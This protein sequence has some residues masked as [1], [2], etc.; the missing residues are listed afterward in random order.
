MAEESG[1]STE[2]ELGEKNAGRGTWGDYMLDVNNVNLRERGE[3]SGGTE[4]LVRTRAVIE[5]AL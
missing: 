3:R 1:E 2:R 5:T 4:S